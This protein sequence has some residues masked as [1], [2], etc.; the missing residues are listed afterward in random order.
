MGSRRYPGRRSRRGW[1][2]TALVGAAG[3]MALAGCS[4][5]GSSSS[6]A[7]GATQSATGSAT[8]GSIVWSASPIAGSGANDTRTVLINSF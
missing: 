5:G 2:L 6:A 3:A 7:G 8:S 1:Q 4:S